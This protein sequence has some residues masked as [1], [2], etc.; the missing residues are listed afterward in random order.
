MLGRA[1]VD[2]QVWLKLTLL[3]PKA[4]ADDYRGLLDLVDATARRV[5]P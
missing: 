4:T 5:L 2:G 1:T 3:H